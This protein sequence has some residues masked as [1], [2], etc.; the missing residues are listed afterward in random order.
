MKTRQIISNYKIPNRIYSERKF[1]KLCFIY[2]LL[3]Y[4]T[5]NNVKTDKFIKYKLNKLKKVPASVNKQGTALPLL[6][7]VLEQCRVG[8]LIAT[9]VSIESDLHTLSIETSNINNLGPFVTLERENIFVMT[10][11]TWSFSIRCKMHIIF[12]FHYKV[13][14]L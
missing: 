1:I 2:A 10:A 4:T 13:L 14:K 12:Y 9:K 6:Q 8:G 7:H 5:D 11:V 3:C